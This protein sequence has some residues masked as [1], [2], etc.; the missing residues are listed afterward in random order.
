YHQPLDCIQ[1][2]LSHPLLAP[3][4]SFTP[5]R[6][7]TSAAKICQIYDEWLSG[8]CAWNIQDALPWGATVL[9]MVLSSDKT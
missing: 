4:I 1:A 3:H 5:W 2:L 7:W 9:G 8:N 6:V